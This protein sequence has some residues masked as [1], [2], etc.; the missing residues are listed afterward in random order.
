MKTLKLLLGFALT[1]TLFTSCYT[2]VLVDGYVDQQP[3]PQP[4]TLNQILSG[5]EL[6][7][8]DINQ[9]VGYGTTP[10]LQKAFTISF[11][12]GTMFANN[13]LV[14]IGSTGNGFGIAVA[15][16]SAYNM[17]LDIRHDITRSILIQ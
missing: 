17:I 14:G 1:A 8:V 9:T 4:L 6:W 7:Y 2:E 3:I 12:N 13:N 16:Y 11:K 15:D 10:F 5:Y